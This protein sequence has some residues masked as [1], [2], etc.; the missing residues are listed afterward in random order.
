[1]RTLK[2]LYQLLL[3]NYTNNP[4]DG[5]CFQITRLGGSLDLISYNERD[6]LEEDFKSNKPHIT[7]NWEYFKFTRKECYTGGTFWWERTYEG[8]EQ[9]KLFIQHLINKN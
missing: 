3:D 2:Q 1:M 9:R 7:W 4:Y 8:M 6:M 5:I